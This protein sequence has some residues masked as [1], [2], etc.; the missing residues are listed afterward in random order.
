M[1]QDG[2]FVTLSVTTEASGSHV[3]IAVQ[4]E[5]DA[6]TADTLKRALDAVESTDCRTVIV[7]LAQVS[8]M[9]SSGLQAL[10]VGRRELARHDI[11][12]LLRN[13]QPQAQRLFQIALGGKR[14][15]ELS[16]A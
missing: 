2:V 10:L 12:L 5:I 9:D 7:D 15:E 16:I 8:F 4:G 3:A 14:L 6:A 1:S 11:E 13:P